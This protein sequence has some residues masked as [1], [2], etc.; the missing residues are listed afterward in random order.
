LNRDLFNNWF[1]ISIKITREGLDVYP[2]NEI[3]IH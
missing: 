1:L 3:F 2:I